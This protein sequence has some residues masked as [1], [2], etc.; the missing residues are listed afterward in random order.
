MK[1]F[2]EFKFLEIS[3]LSILEHHCSC[4]SGDDAPWHMPPYFQFLFLIHNI[5]VF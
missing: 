5:T 1:K 2:K 3:L 4:T